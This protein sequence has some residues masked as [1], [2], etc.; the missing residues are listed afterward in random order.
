M[1]IIVSFVSQKGGAGKS[2]LCTNIA[3]LA[4]SNGISVAI[5][6][7]DQQASSCAWFA[8]REKKDMIVEP[9]HAPLLN[10]KIKE[11][12]AEN[13]N[14]ILIDTPPHNSTSAANA[15]DVSDLSILPIRPSAFDMHAIQDTLQLARVKT[16][17]VGVVINAIPANSNSKDSAIEFFNKESI[18]I[19]GEIGQRMLFQH[20]VTKG[21]GVYELEGS[22]KSTEEI[23]R[24]WNNIQEVVK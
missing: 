20:A 5:L 22:S 4:A 19:L 15:L 12:L 7:L 13:I 3:A 11:L 6:D 14:L 10:N 2:T 21:K 9:I 18:P 24:L 1:A 23:V 17:K 16:S 8:N